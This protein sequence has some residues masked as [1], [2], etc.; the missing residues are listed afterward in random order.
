MEKKM[1]ERIKCTNNILMIGCGAV[2]QCTISLIVEHIEVPGQNIIIIDPVDIRSHLPEHLRHNV[3]FE[4]AQ[5]SQTNYTHYLTKYLQ[6]GDI[7]IDL[8]NKV[9]TFDILT[10]CQK[11]GIRYLNT[12]LNVWPTPENI[13]FHQLYKKLQ[14]FP[15][16]IARSPTAIIAH[17]AN[18]GL[19]SSFVKQALCDMA[20]EALITNPDNSKLQNALYSQE[21][22]QLAHLLDIKV[23]HI[24]EKDTQTINRPFLAEEFLNTWS[25]VEFIEECLTRAEF[26]W[27]THESEIP[28]N[29]R[30]EDGII[31]F[32]D[33]AFCLQADSWIPY[34]NF[35][36]MVIP[37]DE[38]FTIADYLSLKN[39]HN[40]LYRPSVLFIYDPCP[41]AKKS[42]HTFARQTTKPEKKYVIKHEIIDGTD[43]LGCLLLSPQGAWWTGSLVSIHESNR[44]LPGHN[45]TVLQVAAGV[46]AGLQFLLENPQNGICFPEQLD[47][48]RILAQ[49]KPYLGEFLSM[50]VTRNGNDNY[51][52]CNYFK[53]I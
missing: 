27:G 14:N 15:K 35:S 47:H 13:S 25:T 24:T 49:A 23:I 1:A 3:Q 30:I 20:Q 18:P 22:A 8:A 9:D 10:W 50:K 12:A 21:F 31:F 46:L 36:G 29:A 7:C 4:M 43:K 51:R 11:Y 5:I 37:H 45:A 26:A 19:I 41:A 39:E 44:I 40:Y 34:E 6:P 33:K 53:K 52:F 42:L 38:T 17:G 16:K 28:D 48:T 2:A 32:K